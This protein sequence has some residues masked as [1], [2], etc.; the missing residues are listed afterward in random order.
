V[1]NESYR[2]RI[3]IKRPQSETRTQEEMNEN[4]E[5]SAASQI[6]NEVTL[7]DVWNAAVREIKQIDPSKSSMLF[8]R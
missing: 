4:D 3:R 1:I 6:E 5:N 2:V 7:D 8:R